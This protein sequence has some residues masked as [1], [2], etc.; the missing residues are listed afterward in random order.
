MFF[1]HLPTG[2]LT[3]ESSAFMWRWHKI[4][5]LHQNGVNQPSQHQREGARDCISR[6]RRNRCERT[7]PRL[8]FFSKFLIHSRQPLFPKTGLQNGKGALPAL[9]FLEF[10]GVR[11]CEEIDKEQDSTRLPVRYVCMDGIRDKPVPEVLEGKRCVER[12]DRCNQAAADG[13][14][15]LYA[16]S[17]TDS[18]LRKGRCGHRCCRKARCGAAAVGAKARLRAQGRS[19]ISANFHTTIVLLG[20]VTG[21]NPIEEWALRLVW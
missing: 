12:S 2:A 20:A 9:V 16:I 13:Q 15:A 10:A 17:P 11:M 14:S 3:T 1:R 6:Q 4:G 19:A 18:R 7:R 8:S 21:S 5:S